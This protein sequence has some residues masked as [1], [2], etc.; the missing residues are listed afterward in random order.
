MF[1]EVRF[2]TCIKALSQE[3]IT[4]VGFTEGAKV[5]ICS[6]ELQNSFFPVAVNGSSLITTGKISETSLRSVKWFHAAL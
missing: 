3:K 2:E 5:K 6:T 4:W 1:P